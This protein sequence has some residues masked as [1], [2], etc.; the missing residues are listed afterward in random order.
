M[1][2]YFLIT[3]CFLISCTQSTY[4]DI[5]ENT[6]DISL[7]WNKAYSDDSIQKSV[8]GLQWAYSYIGATLPN[9][10]IGIKTENNVIKINL[11]ALGFSNHT[12]E[13]LETL[14]EVLKNTEEYQVTQG[15]DLGR[16]VS[17]LLGASEHYYEFTQVPYSLS[18]LIS[19]YDINEDRGYV[20]QSGVSFEHRIIAFSDQNGFDQLFVCSE[21]DPKTNEIIEYE[22][23]DLMPNGQ[24]RFG[25]YNKDG[26]RINNTDPTHSNAGKPAKCMWCHESKIQPLF[27]KQEDVEGFIPYLEFKDQ[28]EQFKETHQNLQE[29]LVDGVNYQETQQHTLTELVYISF[30]EPS[31]ERLS[32]EWNISISE[33][34]NLLSSLDT[35]PHEE[36]VFL[37]D[38]YDRAEVEKFAPYSSLEVSSSVREASILEVNYLN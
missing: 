14:H 22:T 33:V 19:E 2:L 13:N 5:L 18:D 24:L 1:R 28:L 36:F 12:K 10:T 27:S 26:F 25:I 23:V 32:L 8:I 37:G 7:N 35:H 3:Y 9:S 31:A 16:Y 20:N 15:I 17:L 4:D 30:M 34:E 21:T 29:G 6:G 38:L 11:D